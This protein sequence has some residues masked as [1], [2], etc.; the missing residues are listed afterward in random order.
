[1]VAAFVVGAAV[2]AAEVAS[3]SV[4]EFEL[5]AFA[6][7]IR[8]EIIRHSIRMKEEINQLISNCCFI[9]KFTYG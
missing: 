1:M 8:D 6:P 4:A 2:S 5:D 7:D 3:A 9:S